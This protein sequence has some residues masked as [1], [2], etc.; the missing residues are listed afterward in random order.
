MNIIRLYYTSSQSM[1]NTAQQSLQ[2]T[3]NQ[4]SEQAT[5]AGNW[6]QD[7]VTSDYFQYVGKVWIAV[8]VFMIL[9]FLTRYLAGLASK[10]FYESSTLK[11]LNKTESLGQL[12]Y[13]MV[14][15]ILL[16]INVFVAFQIVWFDLGVLLWG[17]SFWVWF[18]F[19]EVL[20]NMIAW[21]MLL[22]VKEIKL[23]D[24]IE[25]GHYFG[26]IE[27]ITVR[28]T[29]IRTLDLR[30]VVIPNMELITNPIKTYSSEDLVR[31]DTTVPVA[32]NSDIDKCMEV[33]KEA[34]N[35][36]ELLQNKKKNK[37]FVYSWWDHAVMIKCMFYVDPNCGMPKYYIVWDVNQTIAK[38]FRKHD[39]KF[40]Y[41]RITATMEE[42]D[43][44]VLQNI[45]FIKDYK[46]SSNKTSK[47]N[48]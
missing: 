43:Q 45:K 26:K 7:I 4:G 33:I 36:M 2:N 32:Y 6:F 40:P 15:Y 25:V 20:G 8:V 41:K 28:Y 12:V 42:N 38:Y 27:E 11:D 37:I 16:I 10:K 46:P 23:W 9:F 1:S 30:Q 35:S 47:S 29:T 39:I 18:A 14:F 31:L 34:L 13:D 24:I 5:S 3:S 21:V 19:K 44:N 17:I 22:S 48:R